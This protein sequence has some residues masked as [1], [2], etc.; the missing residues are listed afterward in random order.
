VDNPASGGSKVLA[1]LDETRL[2]ELQAEFDCLLVFVVIA[3]DDKDANSQIAELL[4][5]HG[6]RVRW[7]V[8]RNLRDGP[9]LTQFGQSNARKRLGELGAVEIDV[10]CLAEVTRDQLQTVNL[11]VGKGRT[12]SQLHLLD[13]SRCVRYHTHMAGEFAKARELLVA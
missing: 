10:P 5:T 12:A 11:T 9:H 4:D 2:P 8:A 1:Y 3:T 13:R 6:E 7:L